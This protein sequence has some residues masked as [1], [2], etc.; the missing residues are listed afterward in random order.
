MRVVGGCVFLALAFAA[1]ARADWQY[2]KW[3]M[4]PEQVVVAS[5][6]AARLVTDEKPPYLSTRI[7]C[8][9]R[10]KVG[11]FEFY[12][13]FMFVRQTNRLQEVGLLYFGPDRHGL[14][15]AMQE[16]YG[17]WTEGTI[18]FDRTAG[19]SVELDLS[20]GHVVV[21]NYRQLHEAEKSGL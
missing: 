4:T 19:Y 16:K 15:Q 11:A 20:N 1:P 3:G 18:W 7:G 12:V 8:D 14:T 6:G 2:T 21:I 17:I 10:Y 9:A 5:G 13:S